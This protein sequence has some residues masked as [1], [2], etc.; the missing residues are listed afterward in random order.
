[1]SGKEAQVFLVRCGEEIR[2]AK[3]Y[4]DVV[5]R[6]FKN[7]VQYQE[8]R[9]IR[10]SRRQRA[11]D[12]RS[13]FGRDQQEDVWQRAEVDALYKLADSG[14]RVPKAYGFFDGV[15]L[16][17][18]IT[19]GDGD[20]APR[21]NDISMSAEQ[22]VRDH[23]TVMNYVLRMLCVGLVHGDLSEFNVLQDESGPVIIDFPQ[24]VNASGNNNAKA[25]LQRDV[26]NITQYYAQF[27]PHL[28]NTHYAD[29]M[30][31]L[32]EKSELT[33]DLKLTGK[34]KFSTKAA[35]VDSVLDMIDFAYEE[36]L[37]RQDRMENG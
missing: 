29:E 35:D 17:E 20:V 23:A 30:W 22:A 14:V 24:V 5:K 13:K 34:F 6:S 7:A 33:P 2:C 36:E 3:V 27:A 31:E 32:H 28:A 11:I 8:G 12:K 1:M 26:R 10:N 9:K 16:M 18:L 21:L 25:M 37:A 4:K 19:D 15:L